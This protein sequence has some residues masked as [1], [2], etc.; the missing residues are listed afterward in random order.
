MGSESIIIAYS[1][2]GFLSLYLFK[3]LLQTEAT[4]SSARLNS[5][6]N[7]VSID[8]KVDPLTFGL[9]L[10]C[11]GLFLF[12]IIGLGKGVL[13]TYDYCSILPTNSTLSGSLTQYDYERVCFTNTNSEAVTFYELGYVI[14]YIFIVFFVIGAVWNIVLFLKTNVVPSINRLFFKRR[15]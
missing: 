12:S 1:V 9:E 2:L 11:I 8:K 13:E 10:L 6:E 5:V 3:T 7:G 14:M 4:K 15:K